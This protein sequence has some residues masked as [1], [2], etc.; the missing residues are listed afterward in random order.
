MDER[1]DL[2]QLLSTMGSEKEVNYWLDH[3]STHDEYAVVKVGGG[4]IE[5]AT[6]LQALTEGGP[7]SFSF[8]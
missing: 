8:S 7:L 3:Y 6:E 5:D 2:T 1:A 4:N